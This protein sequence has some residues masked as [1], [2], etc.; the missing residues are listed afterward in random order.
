MRA[1]GR[2]WHLIHRL[3]DVFAVRPFRPIA[4]VKIDD[5]SGN[6]F[7]RID[8][9]VIAAVDDV[10]RNPLIVFVEADDHRDILRVIGIVLVA[11]AEDE[12]GLV[13]TRREPDAMGGGGDGSGEHG[14]ADKRGKD[15][16]F[17][18]NEHL[19]IMIEV[20]GSCR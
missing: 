3:V 16:C 15:F 7:R 18:Q 4:V 12:L 10:E 6:I 8:R 2:A 9:D 13:Q 5:S 17:F 20:N 14:G 11:F 1:Y 19:F